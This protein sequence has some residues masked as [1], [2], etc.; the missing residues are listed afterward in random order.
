MKFQYEQ[1]STSPAV[2]KQN[3]KTAETQSTWI[4]DTL[5][6]QFKQNYQPAPVV[7]STQEQWQSPVFS[8]SKSQQVDLN[9]AISASS[10]YRQDKLSESPERRDLDLKI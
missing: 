6:W 1:N 3:E 9:Q 2:A 7:T 10:R 5:N 8:A 4:N